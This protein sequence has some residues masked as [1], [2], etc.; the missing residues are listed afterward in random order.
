MK[1]TLFSFTLVLFAF[2]AMAQNNFSKSAIG[3]GLVV[4]DLEKSIDFYTNVIG[5][6]KT[7]EFSVS[8]EKCTELGLT[9]SYQLDV[10]ILKLEDSEEASEWK[11]MSLG[12]K[13]K[14]PKQK[15]MSDDT[16]MQYITLM[17]NH[18]QPILDRV[19]KHG[20]E[21]LSSKPSMLGDNRYFIL[22][23]DPDGTFIELIGPK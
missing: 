20:I 12:T 17:V 7:G 6:V 21:I 3:V 8:K 23:Q 13:A 22:I 14:H 19:D 9:D 18:L 4:E 1:K 16:G 11:L 2:F 10:T 15:F 5:M